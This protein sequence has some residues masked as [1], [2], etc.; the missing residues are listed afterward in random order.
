MDMG[1]YREEFVRRGFLEKYSFK[2]TRQACFEAARFLFRGVLVDRVRRDVR[3]DELKV[4]LA[5]AITG[6]AADALLAAMGERVWDGAHRAWLH[7][8]EQ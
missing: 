6:A 7:I 4:D 8:C 1:R 2:S 5:V 3:F